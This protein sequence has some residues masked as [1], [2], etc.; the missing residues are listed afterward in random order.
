MTSARGAWPAFVEAV[1]DLPVRGMFA[2]PLTIGRMN[3]GVIDLYSAEP[4]ELHDG[5]QRDAE[6]LAEHRGAADPP[7]TRDALG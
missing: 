7:R 5:H 4:T 1:R 3:V 6:A 2:F